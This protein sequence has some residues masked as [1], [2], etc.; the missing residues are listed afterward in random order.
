MNQIIKTQIDGVPVEIEIVSV[1]PATPVEIN[2]LE[3]NINKENQAPIQSAPQQIKTIK[4]GNTDNPA[5]EEDVAK[6][7]KALADKKDAATLITDL[8]TTI[9]NMPAGK[10]WWESKV[11][12]VNIIGIITTGLAYFGID[13]KVNPELET[14][15]VTVLP[16]IIGAINLYYRKGT[17]IPLNDTIIPKIK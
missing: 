17:N 2:T 14:F 6:V 7:Q 10:N 12:W 15:V 8:A 11:V 4:I 5:S 13:A 9:Q 16:L 1:G 3:S